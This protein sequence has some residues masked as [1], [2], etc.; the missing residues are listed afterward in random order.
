MRKEK[1]NE[2][3]DKFLELDKNSHMP[4]SITLHLLFCKKCRTQVRLCS[5]AEKVSAEPLNTPFPLDNAMMI[6][7]MKKIDPSFVSVEKNPIKPVTM[8]RWI[9]AGLVM[10]IAMLSFGIQ[11]SATTSKL[12]I[13]VFYIFFASIVTIYCSLFVG[14]NMDFFVKKFQT[15]KASHMPSVH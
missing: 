3:M 1:C 14:S 11:T 15:I 8:K 12:L 2:I 7:I 10:I 4:L 9:I 6:S 5:L 13:A